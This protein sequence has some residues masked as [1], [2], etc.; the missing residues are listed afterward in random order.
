M[1]C[2]D[3]LKLNKFREVRIPSNSEYFSR[4]GNGDPSAGSFTGDESIPFAQRKIDSIAQADAEL[5]DLL[6]D[7]EA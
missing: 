1:Y 2:N 6:P 5:R 3:K 4:Y 7:P